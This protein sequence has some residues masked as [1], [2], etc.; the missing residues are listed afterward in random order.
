MI[1]DSAI[2][3]EANAEVIGAVTYS[4]TYRNT[5]DADASVVVITDTLPAG[6]PGLTYVTSSPNA[7]IAP[8]IGASGDVVWNLGTL[9][10]GASGAV[11]VTALPTGAGTVTN[12]ASIDSAE[13][14]PVL[15]SIP[16]SFGG[17]RITKRTTTPIA[18]APGEATYVIEV[19]NSLATSVAGVTLTDTLT[20]GFSYQSTGTIV[21]TGA[22]RTSTSNPTV[23]TQ[24]PTW[25]TWTLPANGSL[26]L[27]FTA[28]VTDSVGPGTYQNEASVATTTPG[29]GITPFDPLATTAEDVTI[30]P[31]GSGVVQGIVYEDNDKD[32]SFDPLKDT[33]LGGVSVTIVASDGTVYVAITDSAGLYRQVVPA[34]DTVV[35][36]QN[37]TVPPD[38][39]LTISDDGIDPDTVTVPS[40]GSA[41]KNVG[42]VPAS[43][44]LANITGNV[45]NDAD[46]NQA[47]N[48]S[49]SGLIGVQVILRDKDGNAVATEYTD[50]LGNYA[51]P[52]I[53]PGDYRVDVVPP[54]GYVVTTGNDPATVSVAAGGTGTANFG[55]LQGAILS[56]T[57]FN[58]LDASG[59]Q[60]GGETGL[61]PG[62]LNVVVLDAFY[63]VLAVVPVGNDGTWTALV[64]KG[65]GYQA[66]YT[67]QNLTLGDTVTPLAQLPAGWL[68]TGENISGTLQAPANGILTGIDASADRSGLNF[69]IRSGGSIGDYVWY[70]TNHDGI[71]DPAE[72]GIAGVKVI[73]YAA[74]GTTKVAETWSDGSGQYQFAGLGDGTYTLHFIPGLDY[75]P[76]PVNA[77]SGALQDSFDSD[78]SLA[79]SRVAITLTGGTA[80]P[81]VDAGF[82]IQDANP[83][84]IADFVWYD[85][86]KNGI[87][88][89]GEPGLGGV[90]VS[91]LDADNSNAL[92]AT[93][94]SD[95]N[96]FYE[97]AGLRSGN[98][99]LQFSAPSGYSLS[100]QNAGSDDTKDSDAV[101]GTGLTPT[102]AL[103]AGQRLRDVDQG[104]YL[105]SGTPGSIGDR[106]WYDGG[107]GTSANDGN[108]IQDDGEPGIPGVR[109]NLYDSTGTTLLQTTL[110]DPNG[111][112]RFSGLADGTHVVEV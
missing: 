20:P 89:A 110:T 80:N 39:V 99:V 70:D 41:S 103:T 15:D 85:T 67:L 78:A 46:D 83:A 7:N 82:Y 8:A 42:Y 65:S 64:K 105:T 32:G 36:V 93:R 45:W 18:A 50:E 13:T 77:G 101:P 3:A 2:I 6:L 11:Q 37:G 106:V 4:M 56:G 31:P 104:V 112:Y 69:G 25:G 9:P 10:A 58:D 24:Q 79:D 34:G 90:T 95:A 66:Y 52:N 12:A 21:A 107:S 47:V 88:D 49:E 102:I 87:Q 48:G 40:G 53:P 98:Y 68:V 55:L 29:I 100:P 14:D 61:D 74:D 86:N 109:V 23:G 60:N 76:S 62:N 72:P 73:L 94:I 57:V 33:P 81:T 28:N 27:T 96:G 19:S 75:L 71:Q 22:T 111:S 54:T 97:F 16:T 92:V 30:L 51:F 108:G 84:G 26:T 44:G 1:V 91:L 5:G 38:L 43:S 59:L 17:L 63:K 35:D